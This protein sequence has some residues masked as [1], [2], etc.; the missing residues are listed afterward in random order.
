MK[1]YIGIVILAISLLLTSNISAQM[2]DLGVV[3]QKN[4][5]TTHESSFSSVVSQPDGTYLASG[6][7]IIGDVH[8]GYIVHFTETGETIKEY[9]VPFPVTSSTTV[10]NPEGI[11][12]KARIMQDGTIIAIGFIANGGANASD[13]S[14]KYTS[15]PVNIDLWKG[16]WFVKLNTMTTQPIIN[17]L[18]IGVRYNDLTY[19]KDKTNEIVLYGL[20][21]NPSNVAAMDRDYTCLLKVYN[22]NGT[23]LIHDNNA[24]PLGK[25]I[26]GQLGLNNTIIFKNE[27]V[28]STVDAGMMQID[29]TDFT[30]TKIYEGTLISSCAAPNPP[31]TE[32]WLRFPNMSPLN[33]GSFF[34]SFPN[35]WINTT[36]RPY[37]G[38]ILGKIGASG[39]L[40][41]CT[42]YYPTS[43]ITY[44]NPVFSNF[45]SVPG[46]DI[47]YLGTYVDTGLTRYLVQYI[48]DGTFPNLTIGPQYPL[49][50]N[51]STASST[52][53]FFSCGQDTS[54]RAAIAKLSTCINFKVT[55]LP[56]DMVILKPYDPS[57]NVSLPIQFEGAKGSVDYFLKAVVKSGTVNGK[58]IGEE[59]EVTNGNVGTL[60][61]GAGL[62][63]NL[64]RTYNLGTEHAVIEYTL[65]LKDSYTTAGK[66]QSCGQTYV[67]QVKT[68]PQTDVV[69]MP[70]ID[71]DSG[72]IRA[73][74]KNIGLTNFW[75]PYNITIYKD[76]FG[77][78]SKYTY[79]YHD[80]ID[81]GETVHFEIDTSDPQLAGA[82]KYVVNFN[83]NGSGVQ[84]QAEIKSD[85]HIYEVR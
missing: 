53:G 83:D 41:E 38:L 58:T 2:G 36:P 21:V 76:S 48:D 60:P 63:F 18:D 69:A 8:N 80:I 22:Q 23:T 19:N 71:E 77:N 57:I 75:K 13:K 85:Q 6:Y 42:L 52:D 37:Y 29:L 55:S 70:S 12:K 56:N 9:I 78:S 14:H 27:T 79:S 4:D 11:L 62:A 24:Y 16:A 10:G 44:A 15:G 33:D 20:G 47:N 25:R 28:L 31:G 72:I 35:S 82:T 3:W 81:R 51:L 45:L 26:V 50:T 5:F 39:T 66:A 40:N 64:N 7:V 49:N 67:F 54:G 68:V 61:G 59:L 32:T 34:A 17:R 1:K 73:S 46:S 74:I 84:E 43:Q 65:N 30:E